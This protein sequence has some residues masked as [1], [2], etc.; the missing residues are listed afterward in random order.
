MK[1]RSGKPLHYKGETDHLPDTRIYLNIKYL[2]KGRY[3]L[4]IMN[5]NKLI[6]KIHFNKK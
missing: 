3:E 1:A 5:K 2:D 4:N 6:K